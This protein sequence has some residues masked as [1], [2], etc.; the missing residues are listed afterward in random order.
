MITFLILF[1]TVLGWLALLTCAIFLVGRHLAWCAKPPVIDLIFILFSVVPW[2]GGWLAGAPVTRDWR[3][4]VAGVL[5]AGAAQFIALELFDWIHR[6]SAARRKIKTFAINRSIERRV[7]WFRN[8]LGLWTT[9]PSIPFFLLNRV[10]HVS[11]YYPLMWFLGF[12]KYKHSDYI[13]VSRQKIR[14]LVGADLVW[15]LYCDWMTGG[16]SLSTEMLNEVESYWCPLAFEDKGKC[17]KCSQFFRMDHW[18]ASG[19]EQSKVAELAG[20][21]GGGRGPT[22]CC[23]GNGGGTGSAAE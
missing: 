9:I 10:G 13:T 4:G 16:W 22:G 6:A 1:L 21:T 19:T 20:K 18:A 8:R 14:N 15:C 7:G 23:G 2:A 17:E 11:G 12:P 5:A 3:G